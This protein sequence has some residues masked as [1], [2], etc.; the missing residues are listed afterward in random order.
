MGI[1]RAVLESESNNNQ[2][3]AAHGSQSM[4]EGL[5]SRRLRT[6]LFLAPADWSKMGTPRKPTSGPLLFPRTAL[7]QAGLFDLQVSACGPKDQNRDTTGARPRLRFRYHTLIPPFRA[8]RRCFFAPT[9]RLNQLTGRCPWRF[10]STNLP[11]YLGL[12]DPIVCCGSRQRQV[13]RL[14]TGAQPSDTDRGGRI[15]KIASR[16]DITSPARS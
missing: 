16:E 3:L 6:Q 11:L 2:I 1:Q 7:A 15:T 12:Y 9:N 10:V 8:Q 5:H 14:Q 4:A 13:S